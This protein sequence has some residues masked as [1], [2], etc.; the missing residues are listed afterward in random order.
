MQISVGLRR[1][2]LNPNNHLFALARRG[3]R[4]P[5][6]LEAVGVALLLLISMIA[7]QVLARVIVRS[8]LPVGIRSVAEI[9]GLLPVYV[10]LWFWLRLSVKRPFWSL[11]LEKAGALQ[12]I[13]RGALA[14]ALMVGITAAL[15]IIPGASVEK[16]T[17]ASAPGALGIVFS[18][19]L[20]YAVAASA[21]ELLFRGWL[22]PVIGAR[23]GPWTGV[24]ISSVLFSLAHA[25]NT[26]ITSQTPLELFKLFFFGVFCAFYALAEG[27]LWG[28]CAWHAVWNWVQGKLLGFAVSGGASPSLLISIR[29][30]GP[31]IY[32]GGA[33]GPEGGIA[34]TAV[35]LSAIGFV[36]ILARGNGPGLAES[37]S[38]GTGNERA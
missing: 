24:A 13:L 5:S 22:L 11:G 14:A 4:Q 1:T 38:V 26:G 36:V 21:E 28:V 33:F 35:F 10:G 7:G 19:L 29:A 15:A 32:T 37:G 27:G 31:D 25:T 8:A 34:A 23:Y 20:S 2:I 3:Q 12:H 6:A 9:T 18:S 30:A 17:R 16:G